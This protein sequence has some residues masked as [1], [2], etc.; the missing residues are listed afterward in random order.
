MMKF[1]KTICTAVL[2]TTIAWSG[3]ASAGIKY[4]GVGAP[5]GTYS[6]GGYKVIANGADYIGFDRQGRKLV[7]GDPSHPTGQSAEWENRGYTYRLTGIGNPQDD[8]P[9]LYNK[10]RLTISDPQGRV[11]LNQIMNRVK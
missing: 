7:L 3:I 9:D 6:G 2:L 5:V 1:T 8:T 10:V 4:D 11:I